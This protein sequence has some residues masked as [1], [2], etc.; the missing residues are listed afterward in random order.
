[1]DF[2]YRLLFQSGKESLQVNDMRIKL[3]EPVNGLTHLFAA[4]A[5]LT[6]VAVLL[7]LSRD[8]TQRLISLLVYGFSLVLMFS[9]SAAY[10]L[11]GKGPRLNALLR[12][13]DHSAIY[14]LIAGTYTPICLYYFSGFWREPLLWIIWSMA[15]LGILLKIFVVNTPRWITAGIYLIMGWTALA[16]I[17]EILAQLPAGAL[18]W[19]FLGG[20]FYTAGAVIYI[21]KKPDFFP[22]V[23]GFHEVWHIFVILGSASHFILVLLYIA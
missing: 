21:L 12:R 1:L 17:Q 7:V 4:A 5:A 2:S 11:I 23:F 10:H 20:F 8:D 16:G 13:L 18:T 6:G 14:L 9:A 3:R 19:L 15:A 22:G